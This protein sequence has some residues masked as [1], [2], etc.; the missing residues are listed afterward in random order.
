MDY[1]LQQV[2]LLE[3]KCSSLKC[4]LSSPSI[5]IKSDSQK[6]LLLTIVLGHDSANLIHVE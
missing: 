5:A 2:E 3:I 4:S 6:G 1:I